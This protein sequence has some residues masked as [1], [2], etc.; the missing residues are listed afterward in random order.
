M[1]VSIQELDNTVQAFYEGKGDL[2]GDSSFP[3]KLSNRA[4]PPS[5]FQ[6][7]QAQQT[8]TEVGLNPVPAP[9]P[10]PMQSVLTRLLRPV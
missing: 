10:M 5:I 3:G 2:V 9:I 7:K 6:Q 1:S 8:L 4:N